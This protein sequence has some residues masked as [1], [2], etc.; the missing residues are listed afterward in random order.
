[1]RR[2]KVVIAPRVF[3]EIQFAID[4]YNEQ[5]KGL[6]KRFFS[7]VKR[8]IEDIR[9]WPLYQIR[10]DDVR[11]LLVRKFPFMFHFAVDETA[12]IIYIHAVIHTSL[13]PDE[14]WFKI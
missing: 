13:N 3:S 2:Y 11:C 14:H 9:K 12:G 4:Y 5:Q 6:V 1:M 10:Y 7:E 8:T